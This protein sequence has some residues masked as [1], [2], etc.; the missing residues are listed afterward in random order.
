MG[1]LTDEARAWAKEPFAP[2]EVMISATDIA[3]YARAIGETDPVFYDAGAARAAGHSNVIAPPY[4]PY[5]IR[6]QAANLRDRS[7]L[8]PDG[9]SSEDVPPVETT[10]AMAGE[11]KIEMGVPIVAGD[12][13][14][15]EKRIIDIYEKSGRSGDLVFVVQEFRFTNQDEELVMREEFTRIYR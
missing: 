2:Y 3:R 6:M 14:T 12:T 8:E 15:L 11:T 4:F 13:I 9:S 5:T 7:D 10:R 1:L